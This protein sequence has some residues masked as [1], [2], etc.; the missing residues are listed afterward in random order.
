MKYDKQLMATAFVWAEASHC[1]KKK[2]GAVISKDNRI[3]SVGY[4]GTPIG[5][6]N[7]CEDI[8]NKTIPTVIHA[9]ANAL[10]FAA[11]NGISTNGCSLFI[12]TSP[13]IECAKLIIQSGIKE[14]V[15]SEL[16]KNN[17]G[18]DLLEKNRIIVRQVSKN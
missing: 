3:I 11:R 12:T 7:I 1:K 13:C 2:V 9:E 5:D 17:D 8:N 18:I 16:Y 14:I 15:F 6:I 4:N 10:M